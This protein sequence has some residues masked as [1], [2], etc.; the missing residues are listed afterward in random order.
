MSEVVKVSDIRVGDRVRTI[1]E[2][3][4][5]DVTPWYAADSDGDLLVHV[6]YKYPTVRLAEGEPDF[7]PVRF[8][9]NDSLVV[10]S[11]S[12]SGWVRV[13]L[14]GEVGHPQT[15]EDLLA[16]YGGWFMEV[17]DE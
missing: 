7:G 11:R 15:W 9:T 1:V 6:D 8:H 13:C 14:N 10:Y 12:R 5:A 3:V 17:Y 2:G 4:V 16:Q